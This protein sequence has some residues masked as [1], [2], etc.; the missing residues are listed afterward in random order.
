MAFP[1]STK[2]VGKGMENGSETT[3]LEKHAM[4]FDTN[5]DGIIYPWETYQGFRKIGSGVLLS[6]GASIFIHL[7]LSSKTRP[8][9]WPSPLLPIV[10]ENIKLGKHGSDTG[11]YDSEGRFVPS[12]FEEIFKKHARTNPNALTSGEVDELLRDN[13]EPKDYSGWIGAIGEWKILYF[14]AKDDQGMLPKERVKA[15]YDGSLFEQLAE[16]HASKLKG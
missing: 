10:I 15:V 16:E 9:K 8:G 2:P 5:H 7:L 1:R 6:V 4:F 11:A 12:K 14:L 13:R 3:P